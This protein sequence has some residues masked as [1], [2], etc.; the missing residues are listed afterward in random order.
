MQTTLKRKKS[1]TL[2]LNFFTSR[3]KFVL[4]VFESTIELK[5]YLEIIYKKYQKKI[6]RG[7]N[8]Q[9]MLRKGQGRFYLE[10]QGQKS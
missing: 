1:A 10:P 7:S 3:K 8:F 4:W 9:D 5:I 6:I 2:S